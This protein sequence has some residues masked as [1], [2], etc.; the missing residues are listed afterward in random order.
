[1][2]DLE[3]TG[4]Q[5][6]RRFRDLE[7]SEGLDGNKSY[8]EYVSL[9]RATPLGHTETTI[10]TSPSSLPSLPTTT[11]RVII[12]AVGNSFTFTDD[13]STPSSTHGM[14]VPANMHFFYDNDFA[15]QIQLW[16]ASATEIRI[17]YY[18]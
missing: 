6:R 5:T 16:A 18:A 3:G 15:S 9:A 11:K 10:G 8:A 2:A 12:Y 1:M 14:I 17:A 7:P 13:G 4:A